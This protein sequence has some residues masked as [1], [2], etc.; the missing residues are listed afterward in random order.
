MNRIAFFL[1]LFFCGPLCL[2]QTNIIG[3]G[4]NGSG[5]GGTMSFSVGQLLVGAVYGPTGSVDYGAESPFEIFVITPVVERQL[6][7]QIRAFP[8]P[9]SGELNLE[10]RSLENKPM[11]YYLVD[12]AGRV[13]H[14]GKLQ[15]VNTPFDFNGLAPGIYFLRIQTREQL[16]KT[17]KIIKNR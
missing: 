1:I 15:A 16:L 6:S 14:R 13:V 8:N 4:G 9:F 17:I 11:E 3:G 5:T 7:A 12:S 2:S 10:V